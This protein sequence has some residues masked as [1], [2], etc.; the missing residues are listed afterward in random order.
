MDTKVEN[1]E[2]PLLA[3]R[4]LDDSVPAEGW[5]LK[6]RPW[7][8]VFK[9]RDHGWGP[10]LWVLYLGCFF[11]TPAVDHVSL[12]RWLFD[13][14]GAAIFLVLYF[15]IFLLER[16]RALVHVGGML[17]LGILFLPYN[18]G[19]CTFFIFA[20]SMVPFMVPTQRKALVGLGIVASIGAIESLWLRAGI[21]ELFWAA[22]FPVLIGAGNVFFAERNRIN[23]KLRN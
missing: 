19:G 12:R 15:G 20:A 9:D 2:M 10:L 21:W 8:S 18:A 3:G 16:P 22:V 14:L 11:V 4:E 7:R 5:S 13:A 23:R 6:L 1:R 17:L